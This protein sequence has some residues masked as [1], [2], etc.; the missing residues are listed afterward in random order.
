M[1]YIK[2]PSF[3][4]VPMVFPL[5]DSALIGSE[6]GKENT[7]LVQIRESVECLL[8]LLKWELRATKKLVYRE[9]F[10]KARQFWNIIVP[11]NHNVGRKL[12]ILE[13][14]TKILTYNTQ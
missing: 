11:K 1:V 4:P 7:K 10:R 8:E 12:D 9:D 14:F 5:C 3:E 2:P 13:I 6:V